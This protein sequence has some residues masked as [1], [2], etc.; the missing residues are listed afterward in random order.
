MFGVVSENIE[1]QRVTRQRLTRDGASLTYAAV[2]DLW[3][4]DEHFRGFFNGLLAESPFSGYR[5]E[6]PPI[7]TSTLD[8]PFEFVLINSPVFCTREA[9]ASAYSDYFTDDDSDAG[10]VTFSNLGGDALLVA[11]SPRTPRTA[12]G[13][14]AAF[15][16]HAP[17]PQR[18]AIWRILGAEA[19]A[20]LGRKPIWISTAGGGVAWLHLR[21]DSQ[22]KYYGYQGYKTA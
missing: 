21:I 16:R 20:K 1:P 11:P 13:H 9:N 22:P 17:A 5:W 12:Y 19:L 8:R 7:S 14:L 4:T 18:D 15:V 10:I 2:L 3:R 6:T